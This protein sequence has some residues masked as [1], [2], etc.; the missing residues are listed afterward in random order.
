MQQ[1]VQSQI[2]SEKGRNEKYSHLNLMVEDDEMKSMLLNGLLLSIAKS[3][4]GISADVSR[5]FLIS[6]SAQRNLTNKQPTNNTLK[7]A[8]SLRD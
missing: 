1:F 5:S 7:D 3:T 8:V 4:A 6:L 2:F